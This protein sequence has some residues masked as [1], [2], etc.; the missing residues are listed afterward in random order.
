MYSHAMR[1]VETLRTIGE[2]QYGLVTGA[3]LRASLTRDQRRRAIERGDLVPMAGNVF[4][5]A[6]SVPSW[7]QRALAACLAYGPPVA[8]SGRAAGRLWELDG[9]ACQQIEVTIPSS[10]SG[11]V[12]ELLTS[13]RLLAADEIATRLAIPVTTPPRTFAD[14]TGHVPV[15]VLATALDD[16]ISRDVVTAAE[17]D[18]YLQRPTLSRRKGIGLLRQLVAERAGEPEGT[19]SVW[20]RR[21]FRWLVDAGLPPPVRQ[22]P[23]VVGGVP[24]HLDLAYPDLW[25]AIEVMGFRHHG[26]SRGRFDADQLRTTELE[27]AGWLVILVTSR[28]DPAQVVDQVRRARAAREN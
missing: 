20:E 6:G 26:R 19:Q 8:V 16:A 13:R 25:I 23:A 15:G 7:R 21:V 5:L 3:Q 24:R 1:S 14:L 22:H 12:P 9:I 17:L 27:L 11:R 28:S 2:H 10:R 18:A 4:A